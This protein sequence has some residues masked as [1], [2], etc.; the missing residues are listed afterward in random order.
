MSNSNLGDFSNTD[1]HAITQLID[2]V[3]THEDFKKVKDQ[4]LRENV[5]FEY[6]DKSESV[7]GKLVGA[8]SSLKEVLSKVEMVA[9]TDA[10]VLIR[11]E[12]GTGKELI[13]RCIHD[14]SK[15]SDKPLIKINCPAIPSG[16]IESELFGHEKGAFTGALARKIGKFELADGGTIFLDELGDLPPDAQV[17]LLRVLQEKEFETVGGNEVYKADVRVIAA[18]NRDLEK[19]VKEGEFRSD[20]Y[21]RLNVF[22]IDLPSL[23]ERIDDIP[24]L[25]YFFLKKYSRKLG[26]VIKNIDE[27]AIGK[28]SEYNWPGNIR[29]LENIIERAVILCTNDILSINEN[30]TDSPERSNLNEIS[31]SRWEDVERDHILKILNR[32]GW[33]VHGKKGAAKILDLNPSTLRSRMAKL[34]IRKK[35]INSD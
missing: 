13:A 16:L 35:K 31:S 18:T 30:F 21:Y 19:A 12:T 11:G 29:E 3:K 15:R 27:E 6:T 8:D 9:D 7:T 2:N 17:K 20:L 10:T 5:Q 22:P 24:A 33:K 25:S 32:T 14:L 4:L 23:R 28:L 1:I 34:G 26:K